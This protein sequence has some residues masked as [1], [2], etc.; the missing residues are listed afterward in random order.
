MYIYNT[1]THTLLR[2]LGASKKYEPLIDCICESFFATRPHVLLK[3]FFYE[4]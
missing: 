1:H 2:L 3:T 4:A